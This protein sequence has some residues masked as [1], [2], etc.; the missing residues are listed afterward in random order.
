MYL[1]I[2]CNIQLN[3]KGFFILKRLLTIILIVLFISL[4]AIVCIGLDLLIY[5]KSPS[6]PAKKQQVF[7]IKPGQ[8]FNTTIHRLTLSGI[9]KHP[10][11]F[12]LFA[13]IYKYDKKIKAGE[14][15]LSPAMSP[16]EIIGIMVAGKI[17]LHRITIPEGFNLRQIAQVIGESGFATKKEF[18]KSATDTKLVHKKGINAKTFEGYLFPD[19]YYFSKDTTP[20][21]IISAMVK[22]V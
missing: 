15:L 18:F 21:K 14:Y 11:K 12:N 7:I 10:S 19:T 16:K 20:E 8:K 2:I 1:D 3:G 5:A 4:S 6:E 17:R 22:L 9:I 13:R